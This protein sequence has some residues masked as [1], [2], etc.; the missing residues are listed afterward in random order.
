MEYLLHNIV[1]YI[2]GRRDLLV[3]SN[4][5]YE[6]LNIQDENIILDM[7]R[8]YPSVYTILDIVR[9]LVSRGHVQDLREMFSLSTPTFWNLPWK[10]LIKYS[11]TPETY[12]LIRIHFPE[13]RSAPT[14][15]RLLIPNRYG[16]VID[17]T[18]D[19]S[20]G[21]N[22]T[23]AINDIVASGNIEELNYLYN[24]I[25]KESFSRTL[26]KVLI[27]KQTTHI[28]Q[29]IIWMMERSIPPFTDIEDPQ[30]SATLSLYTQSTVVLEQ[31]PKHLRAHFGYTE[32]P[33][34]DLFLEYIGGQSIQYLVSNRILP[35]NIIDSPLLVERFLS[36]DIPKDIRRTILSMILPSS[37]HHISLIGRVTKANLIPVIASVPLDNYRYIPDNIIE[38]TGAN[39]I[40]VHGIKED[41]PTLDVPEWFWTRVL[42]SAVGYGN[43]SLVKDMIT[44]FPVSMDMRKRLRQIALS[45]E[46]SDLFHKIL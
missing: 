1:P 20:K 17:L 9:Y 25:D 14:E 35:D 16:G 45:Q 42:A 6:Q 28:V 38:A 34:R 13:Y 33:D 27:R 43:V 26:N 23:L 19:Y 3:V 31:I 5:W 7:R 36:E 18:L 4:E 8:K 37:D 40:W 22:L 15:S 21:I 10:D 24:V 12:R 32:I 2:S 46:K 29:Y 41:N 30:L 39:P 11:L 44:R